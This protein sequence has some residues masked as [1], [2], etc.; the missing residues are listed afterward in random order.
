M[1]ARPSNP[2]ALDGEVPTCRDSVDAEEWTFSLGI[3]AHARTAGLTGRGID[4]SDF[5]PME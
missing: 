1:W 3:P 5:A 2:L 4:I